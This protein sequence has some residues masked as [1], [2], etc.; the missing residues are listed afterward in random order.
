MDADL[1]IKVSLPFSGRTVIVSVGA[2]YNVLLE[3]AMETRLLMRMQVHGR[4]SR[5]QP[6]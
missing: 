3:E 5:Q 6:S 4:S 1:L 2:V